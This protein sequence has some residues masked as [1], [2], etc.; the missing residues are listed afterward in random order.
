MGPWAVAE[1]TDSARM[2]GVDPA[3]NLDTLSPTEYQPDPRPGCRPHDGSTCYATL[4]LNYPQERGTV[5]G[6]QHAREVHRP[7]FIL[8]HLSGPLPPGKPPGSPLEDSP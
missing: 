3:A 8:G 5:L 1:S 2:A 6:A 7:V 4:C